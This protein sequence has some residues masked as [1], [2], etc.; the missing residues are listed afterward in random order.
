M[1]PHC[2][3]TDPEIA[4]VGLTPVLASEEGIALETHRL[5]L[6]KVERA[7]IDGE[8]EGFAELYTRIGS[9][10]IPT[11]F[12]KDLGHC[13]AVDGSCI[14]AHDED[15]EGTALCRSLGYCTAEKGE[16]KLRKDEDCQKTDLCKSE[17]HC[18]L[19]DDQCQVA[20]DADCKRSTACTSEHRCRG[21]PAKVK[22][23]SS[24]GQCVE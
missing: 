15:C 20:S 19:R 11:D 5:E 2:T 16:C 13:S 1:I 6:S 9:D 21:L 18:T 14:A 7:F 8:E 24:S 10:Q 23:T 12:C 22:T 17:G 4:T 3:Y